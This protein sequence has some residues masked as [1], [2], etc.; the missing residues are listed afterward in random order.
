MQPP[1][2]PT[3]EPYI[4]AAFFAAEKSY[5]AGP[6]L[7]RTAAQTSSG[8]VRKAKKCRA[9][10]ISRF[11]RAAYIGMLE[12][13]CE[14]ADREEDQISAAL[15]A[16]RK[17]RQSLLDGIQALVDEIKERS[18]MEKGEFGAEA[19]AADFGS[20]DLF[21]AEGA[22][23]SAGEGSEKTD[24]GSGTATP[25][26]GDVDENFGLILR[27]AAISFEYLNVFY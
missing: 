21:D 11:R 3:L 17:E 13:A 26:G 20:A 22:E 27:G 2:H 23:A 24:S 10:Y 14:R 6:G 9:A 19:V 8:G 25:L 12:G 15:E 4:T 1:P 18:G 16:A 5:A 7:R